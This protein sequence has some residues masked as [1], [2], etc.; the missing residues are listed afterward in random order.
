MWCDTWESEAG[1]SSECT[2]FRVILIERVKQNILVD[3]AHRVRLS[4]AGFAKLIPDGKS[5]FCW[6]EVSAYGCRWAAPEIFQKGKFTEPSDIFTFG[7]I[8]AEVRFP[9][10]CYPFPQQT[11]RR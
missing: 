9:D 5:K 6:A 3:S 7:F 1:K 8:A 4:E 2:P 10:C 11:L